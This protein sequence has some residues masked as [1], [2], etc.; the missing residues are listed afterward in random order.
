[1]PHSRP[2]LP[3]PHTYTGDVATIILLCALAIWLPVQL[4][5]ELPLEG[6]LLV[7]ARLTDIFF[8]A[9]VFLNFRTGVILG[10]HGSGV[11][12][13]SSKTIAFHYLTHWF[14]VDV[15]SS[16]PFDWFDGLDEIEGAGATSGT[17]VLKASR[18][19]KAVRLIR[20]TKLLRFPKLLAM[21]HRM[22]E[23]LHISKASVKISTLVIM[24]V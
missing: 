3:A 20:L 1:M 12:T 21:L 8:I 14:T 23:T 16:I 10:D 13:T 2:L 15:I 17:K 7:F 4:C 9:D 18:I 5:F 22:E 19:A 11:V 6:G 24:A